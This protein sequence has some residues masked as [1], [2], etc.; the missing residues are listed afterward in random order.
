MAFTVMNRGYCFWCGEKAEDYRETDHV[1]FYVCNKKKC[2]EQANKELS[3]YNQSI[4]RTEERR[5]FPY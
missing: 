5:Y 2:Q 1:R 3:I 4:Q